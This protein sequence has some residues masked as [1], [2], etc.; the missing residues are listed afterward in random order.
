[1]DFGA[2]ADAVSKSRETIREPGPVPV[3]FERSMPFDAAIFFANGDA[4]TRAPEAVAAGAEGC[5]LFGGGVPA[6]AAGTA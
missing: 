5:G 6:D 3:I 2:A 4:F 1:M